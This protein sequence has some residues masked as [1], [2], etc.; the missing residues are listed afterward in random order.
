[1]SL[2]RVMI[3]PLRCIEDEFLAVKSETDDCLNITANVQYLEKAMNDAFFLYD[4]QIYIVT[5]EDKEVEFIRVFHFEGEDEEA[6]T[7][8]L[9]HEEGEAFYMYGHEES[10]IKV[11]FIVMVPT[12]LCTSTADRDED[13]YKWMHLNVIKKILKTYKPAGRTFGIELYDYD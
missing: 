3:T 5:P 7:L 4:G 13:K 12:F 1:M 11:S 10:M 9:R 6:V 8:F 2:I